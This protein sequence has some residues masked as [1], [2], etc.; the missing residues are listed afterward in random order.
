M[1]LDDIRISR[2]IIEDFLKTFIDYCE[3][4][5]AIVGAGPSGLVASRDLP[6]KEQR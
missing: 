1:A 5:V 3:V 6:K 4:D 2:V